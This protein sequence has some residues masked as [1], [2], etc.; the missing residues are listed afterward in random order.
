[1]A[2]V[3]TGANLFLLADA[4]LNLLRRDVERF[5]EKRDPQAGD[6]GEVRHPQRVDEHPLGLER[7]LLDVLGQADVMQ[8][9][10]LPGFVDHLDV[11]DRDQ[12]PAIGCGGDH[13]DLRRLGRLARLG[14]EH[15]RG[16]VTPKAVLQALTFDLELGDL[17]GHTREVGDP[18]GFLRSGEPEPPQPAFDLVEDRFDGGDLSRA[19][20]EDFELEPVHHVLLQGYDRDLMWQRG[21]GEP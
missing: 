11:A 9:P 4:G 7:P 13:Q 15:V 14:E 1:M 6:P 8:G 20:Q 21:T 5:R 3:M 16:G 17:H 19:F 2:R 18:K 12:F 10:R